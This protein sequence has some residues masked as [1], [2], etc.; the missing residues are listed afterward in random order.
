MLE[1]VMIDAFMELIE[2]KFKGLKF[3]FKVEGVITE[4]VTTNTYKVRMQNNI[5]TIKSMS[6]EPTI[7]RDYE[8]HLSK[9]T[10][11]NSKKHVI[12]S[13]FEKKI[14]KISSLTKFQVEISHP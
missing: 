14:K 6:I 8:E 5:E 4:V 9:Q 7:R 12:Q 10:K 2:Q 11:H 1:D 13:Y 3:N